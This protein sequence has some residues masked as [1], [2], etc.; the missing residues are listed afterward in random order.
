MDYQVDQI[1]DN[2]FG[3]PPESSNQEQE[4]I[5]S[6]YEPLRK[7]EDRLRQLESKQ[8]E[9]S[10]TANPDRMGGQFTQQEVDTSRTW[11]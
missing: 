4:R 3:E 10:W 11:R 2:W 6:L 8:S 5:R 1:L 9:A 7:L